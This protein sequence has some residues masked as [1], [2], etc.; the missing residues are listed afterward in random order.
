MGDIMSD[1]ESSTAPS[2]GYIV[3]EN[4]T[5]YETWNIAAAAKF[6]SSIYSYGLPRITPDDG[7]YV[8][9]FKFRHDVWGGPYKTGQEIEE[10]GYVPS[11][12][13]GL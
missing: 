7:S 13:E 5:A 6:N 3:F 4:Y 2:G 11:I 8:A 12:P 1:A 10:L 9:S